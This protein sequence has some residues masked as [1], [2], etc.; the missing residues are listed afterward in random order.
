MKFGV[1]MFP[2]SNCDHDTYRMEMVPETDEERARAA[3]ATR[4]RTLQALDE[5][6]R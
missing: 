5:L 6:L 1:V 3:I 4:A 2:G